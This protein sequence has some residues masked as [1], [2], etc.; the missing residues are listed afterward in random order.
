M[1]LQVTPPLSAQERRGILI[2]CMALVAALLLV[3][4]WIEG[5]A[6]DSQRQ[7]NTHR[8]SAK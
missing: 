3:S 6:Q 1:S 7:W 2:M 4:A 5:A 8:R